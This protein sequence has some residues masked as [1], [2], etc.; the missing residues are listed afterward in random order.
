MPDSSTR[1]LP[2]E[3]GDTAADIDPLPAITTLD[4]SSAA[5]AADVDRT[6]T[7]VRSARTVV[8]AATMIFFGVCL[9]FLLNSPAGVAPDETFQ[10]DRVMAARAGDVIL[11]PEQINVSAGSRNVEKVF[12][13]AFAADWADRV[14]ALRSDRPSY[15]ELGGEARSPQ[16]DVSNYM[17]QHP[18]LYYGLVGGLTYLVPGATDLPG[19]VLYLAIRFFNVLLMLP[20]PALFYYAARSLVGVG[21]VAASAAFLPLL[22]P[23]LARGAATVNNDNLAVV[24]GAAVVALSIAVMGGDNRTRTAALLALLAVAGSLTK[25]TIIFALLLIP[26]AYGLQVVR[27]RAW[28]SRRVVVILGLGTVGASAWWVRNYLR[29]G[30][31][32]PDGWGTQFAKA[33]G[34]IRTVAEPVDM[35]DFWRYLLDKMPVRIFSPL[36]RLEPPQVPTAM[37][38]VLTIVVLLAIPVAMVALPDRRWDLAFI[39]SAPLLSLTVVVYRVYTHYLSYVAFS[40]AQGRYIYPSVLGLLLPV[41]LAAGVVLGRHRRWAPAVVGCGGLVVSGWAIYTSVEYF[42]LDDGQ[43]LQ[44]SNWT[45]ALHALGAFFPLPALASAAVAAIVAVLLTAGTV[46]TVVACARDRTSTTIR[47]VGSS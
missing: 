35:G 30:T 4:G 2:P 40:G 1:P 27:A 42:W 41:A 22:I 43:Q 28:P 18:P 46:M 9:S 25:A 14:P 19:D 21:A 16:R 34:R 23:G 12:Y 3:I 44:P 39:A 38:W 33:Q 8:V 17:T 47:G 29:L 45:E 36:G 11:D 20:L 31:I 6:A 7:P 32:Q 26:V 15:S 5:D 13:N 37:V 24:L 10:F